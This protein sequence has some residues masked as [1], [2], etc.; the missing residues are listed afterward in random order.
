MGTVQTWLPHERQQPSHVDLHYRQRAT[1][2]C[3]ASLSFDSTAPS[4]PLCVAFDSNLVLCIWAACG[5]P[6]RNLALRLSEV[7]TAG[8]YSVTCRGSRAAA[9]VGVPVLITAASLAQTGALTCSASHYRRRHGIVPLAGLMTPYARGTAPCSGADKVSAGNACGGG[10]M[11]Q[12]CGAA[13]SELLERSWVPHCHH[14]IIDDVGGAFGM[15]AVGGGMW[16]LIKGIKNSP[17]GARMLGGVQVCLPC[18]N[19]FPK[20]SSCVRTAVRPA[21]MYAFTLTAANTTPCT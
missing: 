15:G 14:R 3:R 17:S 13:G 7:I 8:S 16:H 11:L 1:H 6:E 5:E 12:Q 19:G 20:P 10:R 2:R 21:V 4:Q 9:G 18:F